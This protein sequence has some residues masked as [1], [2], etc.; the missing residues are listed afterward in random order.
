MPLLS[1]S[2]VV[3]T[4]DSLLTTLIQ[5]NR[6]WIVIVKTEEGFEEY[7]HDIQKLNETLDRL[8]LKYEMEKGVRLIRRGMRELEEK[9]TLLNLL[10][11]SLSVFILGKKL[12]RDKQKLFPCVNRL[13]FLV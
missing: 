10:S 12:L 8:R 5:L 11:I 9:A 6:E 3:V 4:S 7:T 2:I 1:D 13:A